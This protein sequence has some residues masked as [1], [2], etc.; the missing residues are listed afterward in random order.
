MPLRRFYRRR[1]LNLRGHH[2][3]AYVLA[4]ITLETLPANGQ[5]THEVAAHLTIA[6]CGRVVTLD[7]DVRD[8]ATARNTL[9]KIRALTQVLDAFQTAL[10]AAVA[11]RDTLAKRAAAVR[12]GGTGR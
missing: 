1:F 12:A 2:A 5:P 7:F 9:H 11:E 3:G 6:D 8:A 4:D 10:E